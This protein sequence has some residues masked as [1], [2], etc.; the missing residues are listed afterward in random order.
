MLTRP[1]PPRLLL[2]PA[3]P[4]PLRL[5]PP[6]HLLPHSVHPDLAALPHPASCVA[7][8]HTW[9]PP[10]L[11]VQVWNISEPG[12]SAVAAR[13]KGLATSIGPVSSPNLIP[14]NSQRDY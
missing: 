11:P 2:P 8:Y 14:R 12:R 7:V 5:F 10:H 9:Q 13:Q 4:L 1:W 3:P 6:L